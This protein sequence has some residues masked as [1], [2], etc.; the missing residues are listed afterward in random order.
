MKLVM[1]EPESAALRG[2][3]RQWRTRVSAALLCT[4][5]LRAAT[6]ASPLRLAAVRR[7]LG[8]VV[9]LDLDMALL[10]RAGILHPPGL[11]SL[12]AVHV[13][14]ALSLGADLAE[15]ITYDSRMAVAA[16]AHGLVVTSPS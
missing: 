8:G 15:L 16:T 12:D 14:A 7:Q 2:H 9:L 5:A 11:R 10:E 1:P 6:R 3:L 13:A 4:E